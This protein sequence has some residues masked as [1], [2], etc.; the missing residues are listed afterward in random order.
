[1]S[2][3]ARIK[4]I[5]YDLLREDMEFRYAVAGYL[6][7]LDILKRIDDNTKAIRDLQQEVRDMQGQIRD[8]QTQV[9]DLVA[10]IKDLQTQVKDLQLQVK[11]LY[12]VIEG[13]GRAICDLSRAVRE[14][15][16]TVNRI[17]IRYGIGTEEAFRE[18]I[19][20][21]IEDLL[22][23]YRVTKWKYYDNEGIVYGH[24]SD[25]DVDVLISDHEHIIIEYK[26]YADRS[27]LAELYRIGRLYEKV[28]GVKPRLLM[29]AASYRRRA[30]ELADK[31]GI[32][33]RGI[34]I[35]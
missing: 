26:A 25:I 35:E 20:Y 9:R 33:I 4:K 6:G 11:R 16:A 27:D 3:R 28:T 21:L 18:S 30:K 7:I 1:M 13:H 15:T 2:S 19:K 8:L 12:E 5:I 29:V 31:L 23:T 34:A 14:L 22:G 32:E 24:P 10:Q 17:G